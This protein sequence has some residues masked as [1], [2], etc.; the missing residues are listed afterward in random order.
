MKKE[1]RRQMLAR[2]NALS[3]A[4]VLAYSEN[5]CQKVLGM[6]VYRQAQDICL[7]MPIQNEVDVSMLIAPARAQG[8]TVWLPRIIDGK[9]DFYLYAEDTL[10]TLGAYHIREP[11]S[12][13]RLIPHEFVLVIMPG[14]VFSRDNDRIGYGGGYYD[15]YLSCYPMCKTVA[16][17]YDF[18]ILP[19]IPADVHDI[20]PQF[21]VSN[22]MDSHKDRQK[23]K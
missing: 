16:V 12:E 11:L 23:D 21:I 19:E 7:Y 17:C 15:R 5:I 20:R 10:L 4:M 1:L 18:Q 6:P 22:D 8:K 2:R 3:K 13:Q 9:M 14:A